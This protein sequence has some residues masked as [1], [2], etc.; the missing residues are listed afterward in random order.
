MTLHVKF[1]INIDLLQGI[2]E[3]NFVQHPLRNTYGYS[4][5]HWHRALVRDSTFHVFRIAETLLGPE[6]D[7][8]HIDILG[9]SALRQDRKLGGG[10][11]LLYE[12]F[13]AQ[14]DIY[15]Q[16]FISFKFR[17]LMGFFN[18]ISHF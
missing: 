2:I 17:Y 8:C 6:V 3:L 7:D 9:Y 1:L 10:D 15:G 12:P 18:T 11:V 14:R 13:A 4:I 5:R 16:F